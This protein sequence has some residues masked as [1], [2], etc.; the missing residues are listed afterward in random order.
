MKIRKVIW[1]I[2]LLSLA[3][4]QTTFWGSSEQKRAKFGNWL[5]LRTC[6][7]SVTALYRF[8]LTR[9]MFASFSQGV[10]IVHELSSVIPHLLYDHTPEVAHCYPEDWSSTILW[11]FATYLH[12]G[13]CHGPE[14]Q[15]V[16]FICYVSWCTS[17]LRLASSDLHYHPLVKKWIWKENEKQEGDEYSVYWPQTPMAFLNPDKRLTNGNSNL[18]LLRTLQLKW[19]VHSKVYVQSS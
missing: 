14:D 4:R 18:L 2:T 17:F 19:S 5:F 8:P 15:N 10:L 12:T 6:S 13:R 9:P 11:N 7:L 1:V 16:T 3:E